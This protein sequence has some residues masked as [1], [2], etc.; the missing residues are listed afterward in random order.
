MD[1]CAIKAGVRVVEKVGKKCVRVVAEGAGIGAVA[2]FGEKLR[3]RLTGVS[4]TMT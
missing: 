1:D 4:I 3:R 2:V